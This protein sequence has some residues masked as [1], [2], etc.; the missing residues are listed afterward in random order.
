MSTRGGNPSAWLADRETMRR[1]AV[2]LWV[3]SVVITGCPD[4]GPAAGDAESSAFGSAG[5]V[6]VVGS[7]VR[8]DDLHW[9]CGGRGAPDVEHVWTAPVASSYAISTAG[10]GFDTVLSVFAN[11]ELIACN[12]DADLVVA[13]RSEVVLWLDADEAV[14]V[15]VDGALG[16]S[17][18]YALAITDL[19]S[20]AG[21]CCSAHSEIGCDDPDVASCVCA[22]AP[23]CCTDAWNQICVGIDNAFC[24]GTCARTPGGSCCDAGDAPGCDSPEIESCVCAV[25]PSCCDDAWTSDCSEHA[26]LACAAEC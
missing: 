20:Y 5:P 2:L 25:L 22:V 1:H 3:T 8:S 7:T 9:P 15:V 4:D 17:G 6:A 21:E 23:Q 24:G 19:G 12:D 16:Q 13:G 14:R 11:G 26:T 18:D 10:S